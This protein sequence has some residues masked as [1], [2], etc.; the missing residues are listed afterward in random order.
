MTEHVCISVIVPFYNAQLHIQKC[1]DLLL[2]QDFKNTFEIIMVDDGSTDNSKK[3]VLRNEDNKIHSYS[4]EKNSGPSA[5]RN[6]GIKKSKGEY[7]FFLDIDDTVDLNILS[8]MYNKA[9][10]N[11]YD[12]IFCERRYIENFKNTKEDVYAYPADKHF[13]KSEINNEMKNRFY[14]PLLLFGLFDLTGRLIRRSIIIDNKIF[15]EERL[16]Y[17]EDEFFMW[18]VMPSIQKAAY[19]RKQLYSFFVHPNVN[20]ALSEGL[21]R[22]FN[23]SNFKLIKNH[24]RKC[25]NRQE[26]SFETS[27][28]IADQAFIFYIIST[29]ISF[30]RSMLLGKLDISKSIKI[31]KKLISDIISDTEVAKSIKNYVR[32]D[33]ESFWIPKA[34]KWRSRRLLEFVCDLRAKEIIKIRRKKLKLK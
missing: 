28:K 11:S 23:F 8:I 14:D 7:I 10:E 19:I 6:Y 25:L 9:I 30:S 24:I 29:L 17:L 13:E 27:Q 21:N 20:T 12:L 33:K 26:F 4:L 16:R 22:G 2:N 31:R 18:E 15:F 32:S 1:I 3:I 5:A 34:I